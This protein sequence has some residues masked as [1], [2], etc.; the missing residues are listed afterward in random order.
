MVSFSQEGLW[1]T[2]ID[3][4]PQRIPVVYNVTEGEDIIIVWTKLYRPE[5]LAV[6]LRRA[7]LAPQRRTDSLRY[8][9]IVVEILADPLTLSFILSKAFFKKILW[10]L[11]LLFLIQNLQ[12]SFKKNTGST[13]ILF[14]RIHQL[15]TFCPVSLYHYNLELP[16]WL[17]G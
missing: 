8:C 17:R 16:W 5:A 12:K 4:Q 11:S 2:D 15:L 14:I 1:L 7:V 6:L 10:F 13:H 3:R 9:L